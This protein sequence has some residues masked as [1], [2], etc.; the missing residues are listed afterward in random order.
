[1]KGRHGRESAAEAAAA[2]A[3]ASAEA[4]ASTGTT[5]S[6]RAAESTATAAPEKSSPPTGGETGSGGV[7]GG[8]KLW[9][10]RDMIAALGAAGATIAA[11]AMLGGQRSYAG[12][13]AV[14]GAVYGRPGH[15]GPGSGPGEGEH[16]V[17][18]RKL[19]WLNV[20]DF[21]A[22][23]DGSR[24]DTE[25]VQQALDRALADGSA[26]V[27]VPQGTYKLTRMLRIY[28]GTKLA[29]HPGAVM[30]RCHNDS[31]LLNG[32][33]GAQYDGYEGHGDIVVEGGTWDGNVLQYPDAYVGFNFGHA[34]NVAVR[35]VTIK[36]VV[37]A[38][39]IEINASRDVLID[40][41][42]FVG[43]KNADDGSRYFSEA[44][45]IDVPTKLSFAAF[46]RH[47]GTPCRN[48]TVR[49]CY[50][51]A[52]GT[53]GTTAWAAGVGTH[54]AIHDV[55][56]SD[57]VIANNT[58]EGL[59]YWAVRLFKWKRC[60]VEGNAI[61]NCGGGISV[62]TPAP[63]SESTKDK[64]GVQRGTPQAGG[65]IRIANNFVAGAAAYG[66]IGCYGDPAALVEDV[67]I[68]DNFVYDAGAGKHGITVS[69]CRGAIVERNIVNNAR[70]GVYVDNSAGCR[71]AGNRIA[72]IAVNGIESAKS[73][74]VAIADNDVSD[75]GF[76]G[77]S[78]GE[79]SRF[80]IVS[81]TVRTAGL[82]EHNRYDGIIVSAGNKDGVVRDNA[83]RK[84]ETGNQ[85]RYGLQIA[86]S[87][88]RIET[89]GN[90]LDGVS[91]PF[92]NA[93]ATSS[94]QLRLY[95]P[96]GACYK[97]TVDAAGALTATLL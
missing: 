81:N 57:I 13:D 52:S 93:S 31:F 5:A 90:M 29:L 15:D 79:T 59:T 85:N 9:S 77:I 89:G 83:V 41:C 14:S 58:F 10:R 42:R 74:D 32:D 70:R 86:A 65:S 67:S 17:R 96:S 26:H 50:F 63:N 45:Q 8:R 97:V 40:H 91:A 33:V 35:D 47:D 25:A 19:D 22:E 11:Q 71:V 36:D 30:L 20:R 69:R 4:T 24:D 49:D 92:R 78:A 73:A 56:S 44:I 80:R 61:L 66:G 16:P 2:K 27:Y 72:N 68:T 46:G 54:G 1:M 88:E 6:A 64:D 12:G 3:T 53:P 48:V 87:S 60:L 95:A 51:G 76:Y 7:K 62:S 28:R 75:C 38:H 43:Y 18:H 94:D 23:G 21:G 55:W 37:W 82:S 39:A 84:A 34:R